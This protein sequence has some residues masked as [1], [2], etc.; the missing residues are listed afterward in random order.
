MDSF[1]CI[2]WSMS[3]LTAARKCTVVLKNCVAFCFLI[4]MANSILNRQWHG[5][6]LWKM[7]LNRITLFLGD[8]KI[9]YFS[10]P[11]SAKH[12]LKV[13]ALWQVSLL[14]FFGY[15]F[16]ASRS[17]VGPWVN[18]LSITWEH[19]R[20][21]EFWGTWASQLVKCLLLAHWSW[22]TPALSLKSAK[23]RL[24]DQIGPALCLFLKVLLE[25]RHIHPWTYCPWLLCTHTVGFRSL[26][27]TFWP[28][29]LKMFTSWGFAEKVCWPL[30]WGRFYFSF[31]FIVFAA[32]IC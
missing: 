20:N 5:T 10:I 8:E 26:I 19:V 29:E 2:D 27:A 32:Y 17:V 7:D 4:M 23:I 1:T 22:R 24:L 12:S 30:L 3:L 15:S 25:H 31:I 14:F 21:A 18:S 9:N 16:L 28:A 11:C 13:W 6:L